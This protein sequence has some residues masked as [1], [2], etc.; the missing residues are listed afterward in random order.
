MLQAAIDAE[1]TD[2]LMAHSQKVDEQGRRYVVGNRHLP[3][4]EI[5]TGAGRIPVQQPRV[6]DNSPD[7]ASRVRFSP[8]VLPPYLKRTKQIEELIP[9]LY[10]KG[11]ST[12]DFAEALQALV[13]E[14]AKG[15]SA[16][17]IVRLKDQ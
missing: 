1:V 15:L 6:R 13:G 16:N 17:V 12:G 9:W 8:K 10:L 11:V 3:E 7:S 5:M 14:S 4:R 2:F